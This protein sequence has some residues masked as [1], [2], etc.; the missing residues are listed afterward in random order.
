MIRLS[1]LFR[2][3]ARDGAATTAAEFALV[4]PLFLL[5]VFGTINTA[6][7]LSAVTRLHFVTERAARCLSVDTSG[8]CSLD[9]INSYAKTRYSVGGVSDLIFVA[10]KPNCG[11]KVQGAGTYEILTGIGSIPIHISASACYPII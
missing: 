5:V 2:L 11:Y 8:V 4:L 6:L 1:H 10:T 9:N 3:F 7:A